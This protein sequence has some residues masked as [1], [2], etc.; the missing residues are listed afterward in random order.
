MADP[1]TEKQ[2]APEPRKL[3][4]RPVQIYFPK[5]APISAPTDFLSVVDATY[6]RKHKISGSSTRLVVSEIWLVQGVG[7]GFK[8]T[9]RGDSAP[10]ETERVIPWAATAGVDF[11]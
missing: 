1:K 7:L 10:Y 9:N 8:I 6:A 3:T 2:E 5:N 4:K 11:E